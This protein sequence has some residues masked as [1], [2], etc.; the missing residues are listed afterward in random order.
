LKS[1]WDL[2]KL[3]TYEFSLPSVKKVKTIS[4]KAAKKKS[5][6]SLEEDTDE[7]K[8]VVAM[9]AKNFSKLIKN[10]RFKKK[11]TQRLKKDP[12]VAKPEEADKKDPRGP[13]CFE[14][15]GYR[16]VR[17]DCGNLKQAKGKAL[18]VTLNDESE[19]E[20]APSK[21]KKFLPFIPPHEDPEESQS[22][23]SKSS[24]DV[25]ELKEAYK[26]LYVKFLKL[27]ETYQ[28]HVLE[29]NNLKT[30]KRTWLLKVTDLEETLL[31]AQLQ[32][33]R[34]TDEKITQ[35]LSVQ[36]CPSDKTGLGYVASSF[37][38]ASTSK[39]VFVKPKVPKPPLACVDKGKG[40]IGGEVIA[41]A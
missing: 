20:E 39:N 23:Y 33:E 10:D 31:E 41:G 29:L 14:C 2:F 3:T 8:D 19:E 11:F 22:Y 1:S 18:N 12:K 16:H 35:I 6:V 32:I 36:K 37:E 38:I 24:D 30:E 27:R 34:M 7:E 25:E 13:R 4:L 15:S 17:T 5:K 28:Q 9:L 21:D 40:I 26:I